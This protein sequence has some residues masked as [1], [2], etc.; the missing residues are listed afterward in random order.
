MIKLI[1]KL[2]CKHSYKEHYDLNAVTRLEVIDDKGRSYVNMNVKS[3]EFSHQDE[4]R[5]LKIFCSNRQK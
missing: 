2:F 4:G 3:M 1:Q 5:T